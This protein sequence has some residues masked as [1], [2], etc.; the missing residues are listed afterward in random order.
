M[1]VIYSVKDYVSNVFQ[2]D[3]VSGAIDVVAVQQPDGSL[4]CSPFHVHFGKVKPN[5]Q[6]QITLEVNGEVVDGIRMKLD[7]AG[8]AFFVHEVGELADE[9]DCFASPLPNSIN[10]GD[11][12]ET[13]NNDVCITSEALKPEEEERADKGQMAQQKVEKSISN[14]QLTWD[15]GTLSSLRGVHRAVDEVQSMVKS[16]SVYFDAVDIESTEVDD[17]DYYSHPSISLCGHLLDQIE[18]CED[19]QR[20][21]VEHIVT[22]DIFR[23][24]PAKILNDPNLRFF[25]NGKVTPYNADMQAYL[26]SRVLFPYSQHLPVGKFV[27]A[28]TSTKSVVSD[29]E[30]IK[31]SGSDH[32]KLTLCRSSLEPLDEVYSD[33]GGSTQDTA[34]LT[35]EPYLKKSLT[36]SQ[37]E[38][39]DMELKMGMNEC[40]FVLR[41]F[42]EEELARVTAKLY[43]WP[44]TAKVVIAKLDGAISSGAA[45]G[46]MFKRKD[47]SVMHS[48]AV[49]F[50]SKLAQ[51]GYHIVYITCHGLSQANMLQTLLH[52][53]ADENSDLTLPMGPILVS[54]DQ[55]L[56]NKTIGVQNSIVFAVDSLRALFPRDVNPFY[57]A[58][59]TCE[60][61]SVVFTQ[62][63]V[64]SGKVFVVDS[65]DGTLH[66]RSL[67]GFNE[68]YTSL[69]CRM[70]AM[71]PCYH[72]PMTQIPISAQHTIPTISSVSGKSSTN[73]RKIVIENQEQA[74]SHSRSFVDEAYND[75]NFWRISPGCV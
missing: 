68:S 23:R 53:N 50:Y 60:T 43:L 6:H 33:D 49:K 3:L 8:E 18:S 44:L 36:P 67:L 28:V 27:S 15:M 25:V 29:A 22:F 2:Q 64:F 48:G 17:V 19:A 10:L 61:D 73:S 5:D 20:I 74:H 59:G 71:F 56:A 57:A 72:L 42:D 41:S 32:S 65:H 26:V 66:H 40:S 45:T 55:L 14:D 30:T 21:F 52:N 34:S 24:N 37:N 51:N 13:L 58:F 63:G 35:S 31:L 12:K 11:S 46:G 7:D 47:C 39:R 16:A 75:L 9:K 70:D 54:S 69:L 38:L 1:N 62:I 4:C